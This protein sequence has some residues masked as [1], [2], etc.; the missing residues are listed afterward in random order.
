M[1]AYFNYASLYMATKSSYNYM[2]E[3]QLDF[4][5]HLIIYLKTTYDLQLMAEEDKKPKDENFRL[6]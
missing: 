3:K 4:S 6:R 2:L 1:Q 5:R